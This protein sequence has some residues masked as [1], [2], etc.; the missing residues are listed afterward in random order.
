M[1]SFASS[2]SPDSEA[3]TIFVNE[4]YGYKDKKNILSKEEIKKISSFLT[5]LKD[6]KEKE[7]IASFDISP[8]KT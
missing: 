5:N 4:K 3:L 7:D 1:L 6:K 8:K 2:L